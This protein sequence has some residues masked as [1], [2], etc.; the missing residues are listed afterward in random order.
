MCFRLC[1]FKS[2]VANKSVVSTNAT[3]ITTSLDVSVQ[4]TFKVCMLLM[5]P[6]FMYLLFSQPFFRDYI[7]RQPTS[8]PNAQPSKRPSR[9]PTMQ[10]STLP[11]AQPSRQPIRHPSSQPTRQPTRRPSGRPTISPSLIPGHTRRPTSRPTGRVI[12]H[13][14]FIFPY[15]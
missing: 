12:N 4:F 6:I 13:R 1:S 9:R 15:F 5:T 2:L 3:A 14:C 8:Q 11:S 7:I 10:P